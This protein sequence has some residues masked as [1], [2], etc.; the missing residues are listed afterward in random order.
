MRL[1]FH[2]SLWG[3]R[4]SFYFGLFLLA[5]LPAFSTQVSVPELSLERAICQSL[6]VSRENLTQEIIEQKLIS[7]DATSLEIRDLTGLQF[8]SNLEILN[9]RNN[10]IEDVTPISGLAN[11]K[12]LDL[13]G[14]RL[15]SVGGLIPLSGSK[16]RK[17]VSNLQLSLQD[18]RVSRDKKNQLK[19]EMAALVQRL[20]KG[21]WALRELNLSNNRLLGLSGIEH[22]TDLNHLNVSR[23]SLID[24]EGV[25][26]LKSL[27]TLY[28]QDNQLGRVESFVDQNK[29]KIYDEGEPIDDQSGNGKRDTDPLLE[30]QSLPKLTSL[31]LYGNQLSSLDSLALLPSLRTLFASGNKIKQ[32]SKISALL[33]LNRLSLSDNQ[34][35]DLTALSALNELQ[36][37]YLVE[38][39]IADL[40]PLSKLANLKELHLQRNQ[41]TSPTPISLLTNLEVLSLSYNLIYDTKFLRPMG[42]LKRLSLAF[43]CLS[44][45]NVETDQNILLL[46]SNGARI[47]LAN[48]RKRIFEAE[49][50]ITFLSGYPKANQELGDYLAV[51]GYNKFMD[52]FEDKT[53]SPEEKAKAF[54]GW[55]NNLK[56]GKKLAEIGFLSE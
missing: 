1:L 40:R 24:L 44:S 10:L 5:T 34:I 29:N 16:M 28:A 50:L 43:N 2:P 42:K 23:N 14:N 55:E 51:N 31:Y 13:S 21:P 35:T 15:R 32:I 39:R 27:V 4:N 38:N 48:Q 36:Q 37:L 17:E 53:I 6:G 18:H 54:S 47:T 12:K 3:I 56:R 46:K 49:K 22:L 11:L 41:I 26:E 19:L 52:F 33:S 8:A 7:L 45:A 9:L 30:I 20:Q 25:G